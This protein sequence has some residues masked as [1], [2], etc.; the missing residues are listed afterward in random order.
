MSRI[1]RRGGGGGGGG[2]YVKPPQG[3]IILRPL[4][5]RNFRVWEN[6]MTYVKK[7]QLFKK[8]IKLSIEVAENPQKHIFKVN[9]RF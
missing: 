8:Y 1:D 2:G 9:F 5:A 4:K 7:S 6:Y 3:P